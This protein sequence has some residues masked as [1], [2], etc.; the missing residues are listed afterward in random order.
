MKAIDL[1]ESVLSNVQEDSFDDDTILGLLNE[2]AGVLSR[3]FILP[4]LDAE[5][6]VTALSSSPFVALPVDFQRN[7]Y[8][9]KDA[10]TTNDIRVCS[11]KDQLARYYDQRLVKSATYISGVAA[12]RPNLYYAPTPVSATTLTLRY[13]KIPDTI[14]IST[15]LDDYILPHGFSD[16]WESYVLWKLYSKIEQG[17]EGQKVD[18]N[19]Y[20]TLYIGFRDELSTS[21]KE[22]VS[23]PPPPIATPGRW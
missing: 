21:L 3:K 12:V 1:S 23:M 13:Q 18:T 4:A 15:E 5:G 14:T 7:L 22:G 6:T 10:S 9:C 8:F 11:S 2:C 19:Y 16:I 20:M 17:M